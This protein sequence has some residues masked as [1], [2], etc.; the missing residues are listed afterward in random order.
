MT[1]GQRA[2]YLWGCQDGEPIKIGWYHFTE[3]L[4]NCSA[5]IS[6]SIF[7]IGRIWLTFWLSLGFFP[8]AFE[9]WVPARTWKGNTSVPW[10][11]LF[12]KNFWLDLKQEL[13]EITGKTL[14]KISLLALQMQAIQ[15]FWVLISSSGKHLRFV[16]FIANRER[17]LQT[18]KNSAIFS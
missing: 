5:S 15:R 17:S 10:E 1:E 14:Y 11:K 2:R 16:Q 18:A 3:C 8:H 13:S 12:V 6:G 7:E 9:L 4:P